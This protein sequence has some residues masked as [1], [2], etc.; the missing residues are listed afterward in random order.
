[1]IN[2]RH[3]IGVFFLI[4]AAASLACNLVTPATPTPSP[5]SPPPTLTDTPLPSPTLE[6]SPTSLPTETPTELPP[7]ATPTNES[8]PT[9]EPT[10]TEEITILTVINNIDMDVIFKMRGPTPKSFTVPAH[11]QKIVEVLPGLYN[12]TMSARG[13]KPTEGQMLLYP[14]PMTFPIGRV[15]P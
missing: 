8:S 6:P 7:S 9:P 12:Y 1:M 4:L 2:R 14:G 10:A 13:Y 3:A 5:T 15:N 11:S